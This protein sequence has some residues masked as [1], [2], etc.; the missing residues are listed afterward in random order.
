MGEP[1]PGGGGAHVGAGCATKKGGFWPYHDA[2]YAHAA[3]T[4]AKELQTYAK[5][6]GLDVTR[7]EQC[8]SADK[9]SSAVEKDIEEGKQA[10]VS[11]TPAFY[12]KRR[13]GVGAAPPAQF[14]RNVR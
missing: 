9:Y 6:S 10:R 13:P 11:R 5:D 3:K 12:N 14:V 8:L 4:A 1:R 7:F 2:L